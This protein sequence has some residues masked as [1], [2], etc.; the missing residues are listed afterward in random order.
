MSDL[1]D[2]SV[3]NLRF[4]KDEADSAYEQ[5]GA[6]CGPA[7]LAAIGGL[8]LDQVRHCMG[9]E[10][11]RKRYTNPAMM[12]QCLSRLGFSWTSLKPPGWPAFG[13]VRIQWHGRWM[14]PGVPLRAR[15]RYTHWVGG[16]RANG[17]VGVFD[18]NCMNSGGWVSLEDWRG[19]IAP[20]LAKHSRG[21]GNWSLTHAIE[22]A[23]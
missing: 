2:L 7:A 15:Y 18:V 4:T 10:F 9:V 17:S 22:V 1:V 6:N 23:R 19:V 16:A 5:W 11:D 12:L 14:E 13:L 8:T 21:D 20:Y 3:L